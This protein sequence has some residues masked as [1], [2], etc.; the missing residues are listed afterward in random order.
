MDGLVE[1]LATGIFAL[2]V[3]L[4]A[5]GSGNDQ[6][7]RLLRQLE[8]EYASSKS[9]PWAGI[10]PVVRSDSTPDEKL[11]A[12]ARLIGSG[13]LQTRIYSR[14]ETADRVLET[15][16]GLYRCR[17]YG[18]M[19]YVVLMLLLI[20]AAWLLGGREALQ[21]CGIQLPVGRLLT[22][23]ALLP[24]PPFLVV[25]YRIGAAESRFINAYEELEESLES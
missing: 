12:L 8:K 15:L 10:R 21:C 3:A 2:F 11:T 20:A 7:R 17:Y 6:S 5:L 13:K 18:L 24:V 4:V 16:E 23:I 25:F 14:F 22:A 19:L 1:F 9:L